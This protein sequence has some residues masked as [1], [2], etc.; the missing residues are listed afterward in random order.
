MSAAIVSDLCLFLK[1]IRKSPNH[2]IATLFI[3]V[4]GDFYSIYYKFLQ[5]AFKFNDI[6]QLGLVIFYILR[7]YPETLFRVSRRG[8]YELEY[9]ALVSEFVIILQLVF[10]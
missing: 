10:H 6:L 1:P 2:Q 7:F 4:S 8:N 5:A 3:S 9:L